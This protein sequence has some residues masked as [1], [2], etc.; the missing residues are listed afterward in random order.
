MSQLANR[1]SPIH[2]ISSKC[3]AKPI[4]QERRA[5]A[6]DSR[7]RLATTQR[8][9]FDWFEESPYNGGDVYSPQWQCRLTKWGDEFDHDVKSLHDQVARC[10]QEPEKL[11]IGLFFQ[12]HSIAAFSLWHLLQACYE[13]DKLICVISAPVSEWQDLRP[14]EYL[15]SKDI[16]SIWRR[17]LRAFSSQVQQSNMGNNNFEKEA[18]ANRLHYLVQGV[19]A[20]EEARAMAGKVFETRKD[21]MRCSYWMLDHIKEAVDKRCRAIESI[22]DS[23]IR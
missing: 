20:L 9:V 19:Q 17:N 8:D 5:R 15:K 4:K 23:N 6:F 21:N 11:E 3:K 2:K 16:M 13:L 22:S 14:F 10:E 18:V 1:K 7:L 12:T